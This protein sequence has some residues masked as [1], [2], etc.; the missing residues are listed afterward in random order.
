M[1]GPSIRNWELAAALSGRHEVTLAVPGQ[2]TR[3]DPRFQVVGYR[4]GQLRPLVREH[5]VAVI[6]GFLLHE[7]RQLLEAPHLVVDLYGPF[8]L[9]SLHMHD[10]MNDKDRYVL[11]RL[12]REA[13]TQLIQAGDVFLCASER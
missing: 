3:T 8:A 4:K 11:A 9:E 2:S 1:S 13:L 10:D 5:E 12:Q 7:N 6:S